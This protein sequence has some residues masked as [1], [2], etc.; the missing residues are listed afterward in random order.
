MKFRRQEEGDSTLRTSS[1]LSFLLCI[2]FFI[3]FVGVNISNFLASCQLGGDLALITLS[4][5]KAKS[6]SLFLGPYS[7][8]GFNHPGPI[9]SYFY[10]LG[11]IILF[12]IPNQW[13]SF[14]LTQSL[15]NISWIMAAAF[16]VRR[17]FSSAASVYLILALTISLI[18]A[19]P[20]SFSS[21]WGPSTLPYGE[22]AI[23]FSCLAIWFGDKIA[24]YIFIFSTSFVLQNHISSLPLV[25][26]TSL[27]FLLSLWKN[28]LFS[29]KRIIGL[30]SFIT[31]LWL[32]PLLELA[33]LGSRSNLFDLYRFLSK[34]KLDHS[35]SEVIIG[36]S[37]LLKGDVV[38]VLSLF[39]FQLF[40]LV[41]GL[42]KGFKGVVVLS[43]LVLIRSTL[44]IVSGLYV[45]GPLHDYILS[46]FF[47]VLIITIF[48]TLLL[49]SL[50]LN[51]FTTKFL[52][53]LSLFSIFLLLPA[54]KVEPA[55]CDTEAIKAQVR[56]YIK[57]PD[58]ISGFR[59]RWLGNSAFYS[60]AIVL[61]T[62]HQEGIP[63]C[64]P[65]RL[66]HF[67]GDLHECS[68][69]TKESWPE[70]LITKS[71]EKHTELGLL[72][73]SLGG[74]SYLAVKH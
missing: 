55:R 39:V 19:P 22:V 29:C 51:K 13:G 27:I 45:K 70:L 7:R 36:L 43:I 63:F 11:D 59:I 8:F 66:R 58:L 3:T 46:P 53:L 31:L 20:G 68:S 14:L 30:V 38:T 17:I 48:L 1:S 72:W 28:R 41:I 61:L 33:A 5:E 60:S 26:V 62:L 67:V 34:A 50:F 15:I 23:L 69:E 47:S 18:I 49:L 40:A 21:P 35:L 44:L 6:F 57:S 4:M 32:P 54:T 25:A 24:L 74:Q 12:F 16:C 42:A 56:D 64:L 52:S 73:S 37:N 2:L 10:A 71:P 9:S 65:N